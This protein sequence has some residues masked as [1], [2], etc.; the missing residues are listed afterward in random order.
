MAEP[1]DK[2]GRTVR[3][4]SKVRIVE[5]SPS[6]LASLPDDEREDV[7]SMIGEVFNVDEID[8]YGCPWVGKGWS[9]AASGKYRGH[10]IALDPHELE[11]IE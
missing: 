10:S 1:K 9:D 8:A 6:F 5:L 7:R 4:G 11:V 2:F 3:V